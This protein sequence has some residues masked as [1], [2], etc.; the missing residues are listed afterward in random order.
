MQNSKFPGNKLIE[1]F[2][3]HHGIGSKLEHINYL[4]QNLKNK[5]L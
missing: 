1:V 4:D 5:K 3:K 2:I